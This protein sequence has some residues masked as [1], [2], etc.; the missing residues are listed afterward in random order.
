MTF[1]QP[2]SK[3]NP[4]VQQR[5]QDTMKY[6]GASISTT[7]LIAAMARGTR[8]A[9][10]NPLLLFIPSILGMIGCQMTDKP[11]LKHTLWGMFILSQ[12]A[13]MAGLIS[14]YNMPIIFNAL[15]ATGIMV[16]GLG[17]YAYNTPTQNF[18]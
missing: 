6:F 7:G 5:V 8:L 11:L 3:Y 16:G 9:T 14:M 4:V 18:L 1:S 12:G 2:A 10:I 15:A 13:S 17:F